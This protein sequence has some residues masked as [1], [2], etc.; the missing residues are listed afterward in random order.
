MIHKKLIFSNPVVQELK[1]YVYIKES[2]INDF[3]FLILHKGHVYFYK[4]FQSDLRYEFYMEIE[5]LEII[6]HDKH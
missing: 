1:N 6:F 3:Y 5:D 2:K 4:N